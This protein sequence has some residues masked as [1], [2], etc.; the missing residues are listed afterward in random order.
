MHHRF[1]TNQQEIDEIIKKCQ[2]CYVSMVDAENLPYVLPFN[3]GYHDGIVFLHSSKKGHKIDIL[4]NNPSVCI[5][6]STD[7][8]LRYQSEQMA[9]SYSMKY[10]SVLAFGKV[11]FVDELEKKI[12][13]MNAVMAN[14]TDCKFKY[15]EPSLRE[16]CTYFVK[17][18]KFTAKVYGY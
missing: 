16:V 14:Y 10:R 18:E 3:F 9:C 2:V 7:H 17:V 13:F 5:A 4:R 1:I 11:E 15:N 12:D 6:F 8:Q